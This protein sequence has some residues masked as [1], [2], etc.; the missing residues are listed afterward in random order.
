LPRQNVLTNTNVDDEFVEDEFVECWQ[1]PL[2]RDL[3]VALYRLLVFRVPEVDEGIVLLLLAG[4]IGR[5]DIGDGPWADAVQPH[6][7]LFRGPAEGWVLG[8]MMAMVRPA[9]P[10]SLATLATSMTGAWPHSSGNAALRRE[11]PNAAPDMQ[12]P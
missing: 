2:H 4:I 10:K 12:C 9:S 7:R 8:C 11:Q 1:N 6:D 5:V 3:P